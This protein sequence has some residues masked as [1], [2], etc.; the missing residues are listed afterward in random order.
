MGGL[1]WSKTAELEKQLRI[2]RYNLT[3]S[4]CLRCSSPLPYEKRKQTFCGHSC[5]AT[6]QNLARSKTVEWTCEGCGKVSTALPHKTKKFC[7]HVCQRIVTK[8]ETW[9]RLQRGEI[10]ERSVIRST[11]KREVGEFC[12]NCKRDEWLGYPIPLEVHHVDG[13]A[14]NNSFDNLSLLCPNCHGITDTWKGRNKG[15]GRAARG[16]KLS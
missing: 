15:R 13:N 7:G 8:R 2:D 9:E 1:G 3:P 12:F 14:G 4:T 6:H 16:L 5:R 10:S 11:L